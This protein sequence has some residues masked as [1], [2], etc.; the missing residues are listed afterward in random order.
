M[1]IN[2]YS[3]DVKI[4]SERTVSIYTVRL[5]E[6]GIMHAHVSTGGKWK[7]E[8]FKLLFPVIGEM[9]NFKKVPLLVSYDKLVFPTPESS[10]YWSNPETSC[11]YFNSEAFL[12]DS[13]PLKILGNFYLRFNKPFRPTKIFDS[14]KEAILWLRSFI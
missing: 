8:D 10:E 14:Q 11:P 5:R 13:L 12:L 9:V 1:I 7:A 6:D 4:I 3:T 2:K